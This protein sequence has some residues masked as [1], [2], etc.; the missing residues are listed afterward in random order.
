MEDKIAAHIGDKLGIPRLA[1]LLAEGLTGSE[2]NSLLLAVYEKRV[3]GLR[4]ALLLQ[5]YRANRFVQPADLDMIE[6][7]EWGLRALR[8]LKGCDFQPLELSPVAQWGSCSV[9]GTTSQKK[10]VS[11]V[12]NTEVVADATNAMALYIADRRKKGV[13]SGREM[14]RLCTVH[15]HVRAQ[16]VRGKG[17]FPH[18]KIGCLV[19]AGRDQGDHRWE[20]QALKEQL[21]A[22]SSLFREEFGVERIRFKL[23]KREGNAQPVAGKPSDDGL[24]DKGS[25]VGPEKGRS[26]IDRLIEYLGEE[27]LEAGKQRLEVGREDAP[28][29]NA[30]YKGIQFKMII[31]AAGREWEIADGGFVD[32]TQQLLEDKKERMLIAGFGLDFLYRIRQGMV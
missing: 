1:D 18:F 23:L 26:L 3:D 10:V 30:Y 25:T 22:L 15:R 14:A 17:F 19:S 7:T 20:C 8:H 4:P 27:G 5:Q 24:T 21:T 32:W 16:E 28:P 29:P 2:L 11:A 12:R 13:L 31:E 9:V 6:L